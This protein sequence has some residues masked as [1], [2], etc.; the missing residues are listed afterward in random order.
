MQRHN[1]AKNQCEQKDNKNEKKIMNLQELQHILN[2]MH[3][4]SNYI[5]RAVKVYEVKFILKL[6]YSETLSM[7]YTE[8]LWS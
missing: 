6:K 2:S 8:T 7:K 1:Q 5:K 3:I 4:P